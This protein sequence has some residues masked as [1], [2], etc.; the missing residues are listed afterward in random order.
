[1]VVQILYESLKNRRDGNG[2][3]IQGFS[4]EAR[5]WALILNTVSL[6]D[7]HSVKPHNWNGF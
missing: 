6:V 4:Y 2:Q 1:M 7:D 5:L 3:N